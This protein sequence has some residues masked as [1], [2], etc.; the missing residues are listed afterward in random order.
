[1]EAEISESVEQLQSEKLTRTEKDVRKEVAKS[2]AK[3]DFR[4]M[5]GTIYYTEIP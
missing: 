1:M 2:N 5:A 4:V 3:E